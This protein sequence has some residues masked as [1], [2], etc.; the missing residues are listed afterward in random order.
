MLLNGR[1]IPLESS[2]S[3]E[4]QMK[5]KLHKELRAL[6]REYQ[7]SS[8]LSRFNIGPCELELERL[9]ADIT[10]AQWY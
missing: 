6:V 2:T 8:L 3:S 1:E 4:L 5:N 9:K 10:R 7:G